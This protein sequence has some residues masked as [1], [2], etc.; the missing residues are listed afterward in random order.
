PRGPVGPPHRNGGARTVRRREVDDHPGHH[1][2]TSGNDEDVVVGQ[3][4]GGLVAVQKFHLVKSLDIAETAE[5][6]R[7]CSKSRSV[8]SLDK[9]TTPRPRCGPR[10]TACGTAR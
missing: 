6:S 8:S 9:K 1:I 7:F 10:S 3:V 5:R 4:V 2:R